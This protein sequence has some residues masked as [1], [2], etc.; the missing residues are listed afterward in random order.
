MVFARPKKRM[1]LRQR[2]KALLSDRRGNVLILASA[3]MPLL[4]GSAGL[5]IDTVQLSLMKRHLQRA[6]DSAALAG[7]YSKAQRRTEA[8]VGSAVTKALGFSD[9]YPA[10]A[11]VTYPQNMFAGLAVK[12]ALKAER[13][14]PFMSFFTG[15]KPVIEVEA[16]AA[17]V[18]S[19]KYC[20]VSLDEG[21]SFPGITFGGSATVNLGCGIISNTGG[22][23]AVNVNSSGN[24]QATSVTASPIAAVGGV[25]TST[26]YK[27]PTL[28]LPYSLK[29]EDPFKDVPE[30]NPTSACQPMITDRSAAPVPG[31]CYKGM[32]VDK[33]LTLSPGTYYIAGDLTLNANANITAHGVTFVFTTDP[34]ASTSYYPKIA[35]D[36]NA[37]LDLTAPT[38]GDYEGIIMYY[39]KDAPA[40]GH[41]INGNSNMKL[42]GAFYFPTQNLTF[43]GRS[44]MQTSCI[45]LV[46]YRLTFEGNTT[47]NN[48]CPSGGGAKS[49]DATWVRLVA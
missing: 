38:Y 49:F 37:K 18:Y 23:N 6:A 13:T 46:A 11:T 9:A 41:W 24:G 40:Q 16:T 39:D 27:Q 10:T 21:S 3:G 31:G 48:Q 30:P 20:M 33:T 47:I 19:G 44:G 42:E 26:A 14:T 5:A 22:A 4:I 34:A 2:L 43:N 15:S 45:Q 35:I 29:Q 8:E 7:A 1:S 32:D 25:P 12:V 36:G 28:L 17:L